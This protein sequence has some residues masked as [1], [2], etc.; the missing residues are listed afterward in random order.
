MSH[1]ILKAARAEI[2]AVLRKHDVAGHVVLHRQ[3]PGDTEGHSEVFFD[4]SPSYSLLTQE[5]DAQGRVG[6]RLRVKFRDY[7]NAQAWVAAVAPSC[8]LIGQFAYLLGGSAMP[9]IEL[10]AALDKRLGAE[11]SPL[12]STD[13]EPGVQ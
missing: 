1:P 13:D 8:N 4:V 3:E 6:V 10:S 5:R 7:P 12:R 11:H 9:F 2:E